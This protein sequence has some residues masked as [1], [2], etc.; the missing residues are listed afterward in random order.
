M[1]DSALSIPEENWRSSEHV[2]LLCS[3]H[4]ESRAFGS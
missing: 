4:R 3:N 1:S 2:F